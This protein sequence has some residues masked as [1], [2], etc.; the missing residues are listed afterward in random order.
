M[1]YLGGDPL[2]GEGGA[3]AA[4]GFGVWVV[5]SEAPAI[6]VVAVLQDRAC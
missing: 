4:G 5:E 1:W 6:Q 3:A 2:Y